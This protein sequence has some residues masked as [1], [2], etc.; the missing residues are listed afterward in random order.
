MYQGRLAP[1]IELNRATQETLP[2]EPDRFTKIDLME[3][4]ASYG[5][6]G[7][8]LQFML[9]TTLSDADKYP[10]KLVRPLM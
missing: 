8:A 4:E 9:D 5:K 7:F 3:R 2:T 10:L 1:F 6:A